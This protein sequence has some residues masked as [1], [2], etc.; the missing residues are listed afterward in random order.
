M[1]AVADNQ[2]RIITLL[3]ESGK[4]SVTASYGTDVTGLPYHA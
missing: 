3:I 1:Y 4:A 2:P